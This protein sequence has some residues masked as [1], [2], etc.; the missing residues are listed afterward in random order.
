ME[1]N[2]NAISVIN[3]YKKVMTI[4]KTDILN[5]FK[6]TIEID[7]NE[8]LKLEYKSFK[9]EF[10]E[11]V[12]EYRIISIAIDS[13]IINS[14]LKQLYEDLQ[15]TYNKCLIDII[16]KQ[17]CE[18]VTLEEAKIIG[19]KYDFVGTLENAREYCEENN[20]VYI[21]YPIE[22][23]KIEDEKKIFGMKVYTDKNMVSWCRV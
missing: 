22:G 13:V 19:S 21:E 12:K 16:N 3:N 17:V 8:A 10:E 18:I 14:G 23:L 6:Y 9:N 4:L 1:I 11:R 15:E 2:T 7:D 5:D 20:L